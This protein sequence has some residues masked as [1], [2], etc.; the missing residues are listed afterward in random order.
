MWVSSKTKTLNLS[1]ARPALPISLSRNTSLL[2]KPSNPDPY[3]AP[4]SPVYLM[5]E[6]PYPGIFNASGRSCDVGSRL[7]HH[8][9]SLHLYSSRCFPSVPLLCFQPYHASHSVFRPPPHLAA[10]GWD[11]A[12]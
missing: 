12:S 7:P 2:P 3:P 9:T 5:Y 10:S 11:L 6:S 8:Q 4:L 1:C